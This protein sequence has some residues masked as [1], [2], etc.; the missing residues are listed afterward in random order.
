MI[1]LILVFEQIFILIFFA[2]IGYL[3]CHAGIL[4][5]KSAKLLS[6]LEVYVFLPATVFRTFSKNF[7]VKYLA[8]KYYYIFVS[9]IVLCLV[10][11]ISH[12]IAKALTKDHYNR[13]VYEYSI[14][15]ANYGYMGYALTSA[16]FGEQMLLNLM[17]FGFPISIYIYTFGFCMLTKSKINI[18]RLLNPMM[19]AILLGMLVGI[20]GLELPSVASEILNKGAACMSPVAMLLTGIS[21]AAFKITDLLRDKCYYIVTA[22]RLVIMPL[23]ICG[24]LKVLGLSDVII[25][26]LMAY[27]MPCGLNTIVFPRLV[28][29]KCEIGAGLAFIS[30]ILSLITLPIMVQIFA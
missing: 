21:L 20:T 28:G 27:A 18:K 30:S 1:Y 12:F 11:L 14:A 24:A 17:M 25:P 19:I 7:T 10:A 4:D 13:N 26:A 8:E 9:I 23:A 6:T 29:E 16:I 15:I 5:G 3:L 22:L 2:S